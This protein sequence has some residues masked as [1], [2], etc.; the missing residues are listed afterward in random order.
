MNNS[1]ALTNFG[2]QKM[3]MTFLKCDSENTVFHT[4]FP[5]AL[6]AQKTPY[7]AGKVRMFITV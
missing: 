1:E 5:G 3:R 4:I 6:K 7:I 2:E